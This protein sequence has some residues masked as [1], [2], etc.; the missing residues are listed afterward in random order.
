MSTQSVTFYAETIKKF[1]FP[2]CSYVHATSALPIIIQHT[3]TIL[4]LKQLVMS[5]DYRLGVSINFFV[6]D[7]R[8]RDGNGRTS[9]HSCGSFSVT[10]ENALLKYPIN[11]LF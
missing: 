7:E 9:L 11:Q 3:V 10:K 5:G 2:R 8:P 4:L 6:Q 1:L